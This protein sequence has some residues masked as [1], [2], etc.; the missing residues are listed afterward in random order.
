ML[1]RL[2]A[3][4]R[5]FAELARYFEPQIAEAK[6]AEIDA[7]EAA[8]AQ[9]IDPR[10]M[11]ATPGAPIAPYIAGVHDYD[12]ATETAM[13]AEA[14]TATGRQDSEK[15]KADAAEKGYRYG[16]W[17]EDKDGKASAPYTASGPGGVTLKPDSRAE[18]DATQPGGVKSENLFGDGPGDNASR[19]VN[20]QLGPNADGPQ[21][22]LAQKR[23]GELGGGAGAFEPSSFEHDDD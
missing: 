7:Q 13:K 4:E 14:D 23:K 6:K 1:D 5:K 12:E 15:R 11:P 9:T 16:Q 20:V 2:E 17:D 3:L 22:T 8:P 21:E 19:E 10:R 18:F